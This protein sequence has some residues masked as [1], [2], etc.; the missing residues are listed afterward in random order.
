MKNRFSKEK[1]GSALREAILP[2]LSLGV[3]LTLAVIGLNRMDSTAQSEHLRT[4]ETAI[5][6]AAVQCYA[7]EGQY[8]P[9]LDYLEENYGLML[10]RDKFIIQYDVI[11]SNLM[12][13]ILVLP[14]H[15]AADA[16]PDDPAMEV[17]AYANADG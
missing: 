1:R 14:R 11:G 8:P 13:T 10:D 7:L 3:V 2:V 9:S 12:P 6:R 4:T 17:P 15:F 5:T 16:L